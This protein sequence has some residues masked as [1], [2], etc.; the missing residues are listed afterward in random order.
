MASRPYSIHAQGV[1]T[2]YPLV[3]ETHPGTVI[4]LLVL[5]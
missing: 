1:K 5:S 4:H 3:T 2:K